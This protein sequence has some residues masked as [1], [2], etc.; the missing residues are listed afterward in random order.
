MFSRRVD[1]RSCAILIG[2]KI[3]PKHT[4]SFVFVL[5][6][7]KYVATDR[8]LHKLIPAKCL[9]MKTGRW[10]FDSHGV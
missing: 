8:A 2:R 7:R 4:E 3:P 10:G 5:L 9:V 6:L 1:L